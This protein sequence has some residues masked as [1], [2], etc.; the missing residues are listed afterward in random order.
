MKDLIPDL[1]ILKGWAMAQPLASSGNL[2]EMQI[3]APS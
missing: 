3:Q 1:I 2:L